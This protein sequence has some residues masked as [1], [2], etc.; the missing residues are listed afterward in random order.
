MDF[1]LPHELKNL[2]LRAREFIEKE[3]LPLENGYR[4]TPSELTPEVV[5]SLKKKCREVKLVN[6]TVPKEY[7]GL[8]LGVLAQIVRD[9]EFGKTTLDFINHGIGGYGSV[10]PVFYES[11]DYIKEKYMW[12]LIRGEK[13]TGWAMTEPGAGSDFAGIKTTA[14]RQGDNYVLNGT[15]R[16]S[17]RCHFADF[18]CVFAYTNKDKGHRGVSVFLVDKGTPGFIVEKTFQIMGVDIE[19]LIRFENC[20]VPAKNM[21]GGEGMGFYMGVKQFNSARLTEPA[22]AI[23]ASERCL[24]LAIEYA[25]SRELFGRHLGEF[26]AIQWMLA[27][28]K[29]D[30]ECMRWML[31]HAAWKTDKGEEDTRLEC[32]MVKAL[33]IEGALRII[34]RSMQVYGGIGLSEYY[35]FGYFY[36]WYRMLK[37]AEGSMEIMRVIISRELLGRELGDLRK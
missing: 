1:E 13:E 28:S 12:P 27:D 7:G 3:A 11:S 14:V 22:H 16:F 33:G 6:I 10:W 20:V 29:I 5:A 9:M 32:A 34:D 37:S 15:K 25:K 35:P 19:P 18:S 26:Q 24:N 23:G 21:L 30:L 36:N 8:G 2:Q 17:S 31:Y 4:I